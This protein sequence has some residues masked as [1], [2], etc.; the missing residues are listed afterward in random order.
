MR[1]MCFEYLCA[2]IE[3]CG[4]AVLTCLSRR[5]GLSQILRMYIMGGYWTYGTIIDV[6]QVQ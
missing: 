1:S 6:S 4:A 3:S 2:E 5:S